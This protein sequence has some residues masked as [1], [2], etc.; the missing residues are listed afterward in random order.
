MFDMKNELRSQAIQLRK[1]GLSYA[2]ILRKVPVAKSTLSLWLRSVALSKP[3][4]QKLT[5][6]KLEAAR[7]GGEAKRVQR[8][9]TTEKIYESAIREIHS[10]SK[11]ELWFMGVM[12]YW[13]EGSKEKEYRPGA[14]IDF[15]NSDPRMIQLFLKW[16][17]DVCGVERERIYFGIFIHENSRHRV[18]VVREHWMN[19]TGFSSKHFTYTYFKKHNPRTKRKNISHTYMGNL[20]IRV[21]ASSTLV[22]KVEGWVRG[23]D[24][25]Y[26]RVV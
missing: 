19:H 6:K 5:R 4:H 21:K 9:A 18:D 12:L 15:S 7:R 8:I 22:R 10:I 26:C 16:L 13:A 24:T 1:K 23:I 2:E 17:T 25:Y 20:R 11:R 3:Q 14:G